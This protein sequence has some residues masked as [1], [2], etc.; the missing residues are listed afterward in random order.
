MRSSSDR[1]WM[2]APV[3]RGTKIST[4]EMAKLKGVTLSSTPPGGQP[5]GSWRRMARVKLYWSCTIPLGFPVEPEVY[6]TMAASCQPA[7]VGRSRGPHQAA[8]AMKASSMRKGQAQSC[9]I[10]RTR[11]SGYSTDR[12]EKAAPARSTPSSAAMYSTP[13]GSRMGRT[14]SRPPPHFNTHAAMRPLSSSSSP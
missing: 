9:R 4:T 10:K 1:I 3:Q 12:G 11:S 7:G 13:R 2:V 14:L 8:C 5:M 6:S